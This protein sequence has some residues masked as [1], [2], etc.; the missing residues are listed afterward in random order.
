ML[1]TLPLLALLVSGCA[2]SRVS[3]SPT[4]LAESNALLDGRHARVHLLDG[5]Q[6]R[7]EVVELGTLQT[8]LLDRETGSQRAIPTDSVAS[9][10][11][12]APSRVAH[13]A[14]YGALPGLAIATAG[15][16]QI[17][18]GDGFKGLDWLFTGLA[19]IVPGSLGAALLGDLDAADEWIEVYRRRSRFPP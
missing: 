1:R 12:R 18:F 16:G 2:V 9:V 7:A 15:V 17:A 6:I 14:L 10:R 8:T 3:T 5:R 19:L 4:T 11:V 13:N